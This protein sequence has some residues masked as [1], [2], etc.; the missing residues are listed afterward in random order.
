MSLYS[1]NDFKASHSD[2]VV[3]KRRSDRYA[4][5]RSLWMDITFNLRL[6][7]AFEIAQDI[8]H[9]G[10]YREPG[11]VTNTYAEYL[12]KMFD[13]SERRIVV[14]WWIHRLLN[15][16]LK[17]GSKNVDS[18]LWR[19]RVLLLRFGI[20]THFLLSTGPW[21]LIF[22]APAMYLRTGNSI[23][24]FKRPSVEGSPLIFY[25]WASF[26]PTYSTLHVRVFHVIR[27][28]KFALSF[29]KMPTMYV[30]RW[31]S[32]GRHDLYWVCSWRLT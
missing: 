4:T 12:N 3:R 21:L 16:K 28:R 23:E 6:L 19:L 8:G 17:N 18:T 14:R 29:P 25:C 11:T 31:L 2:A 5:P 1:G 13:I 7:T 26:G 30:V 32:Y 10:T 15:F 20:C 24:C 22:A 9:A 27:F